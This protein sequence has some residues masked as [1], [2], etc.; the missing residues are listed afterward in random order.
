MSF[1]DRLLESRIETQA[2]RLSS[3]MKWG[4]AK[5]ARAE[6]DKLEALIAQRSPEAVRAMERKKGISRG[7]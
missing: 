5:A 4:G 1:A 6:L 7:G 2:K 3:V